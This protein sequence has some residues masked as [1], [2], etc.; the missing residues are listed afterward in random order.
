MNLNTINSTTIH[1]W[2]V[3]GHF[4]TY[5]RVIGR[6]HLDTRHQACGLWIDRID[7]VVTHGVQRVG[8]GLDH[9][10]IAGGLA[11][12]HNAVLSQ[13][14]SHV[15]RDPGLLQLGQLVANIQ[16]WL[17]QQLLAGVPKLAIGPGQ[18]TIVNLELHAGDMRSTE[19]L[20]NWIHICRLSV[21]PE[22]LQM[23]WE[24]Q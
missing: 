7:H 15:E 5:S 16:G 22:V 24:G 18:D 14:Q 6:P 12:P 9:G 13:V 19:T 20:Y 21:Q 2:T 10:N 3:L 8:P 4:V 1:K 11:R 23:V 17:F